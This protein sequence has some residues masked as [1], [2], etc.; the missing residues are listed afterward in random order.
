[1]NELDREPIGDLLY[2]YLGRRTGERV[3][4][5]HVRRGD[6]EKIHAVI[7]FCDLRDSTRL[8]ESM[9][10]EDFFALL[11]D[12][13]ECTAGAVL[14]HGGEILSYIGDAALAIFPIAGTDKPF[15][16]ACTPEE[17]ACA[18]ALAAARDALARVEALNSE[19]QRRGEEALRFGIALHAGDVMYGNIGVPGR[20][21]F[22]VIGAATN[23][24]SRLAG[25]CKTLDKAVLVSSR[26]PGCFP[27]QLV[28][29]GRHALQGI[30]EPQ[31]VF[32]LA[33]RQ[34]AGSCRAGC[35]AE[36]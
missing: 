18:A 34:T 14:D 31:E 23:E 20:L 12:F 19:R 13:F 4:N 15:D 29:L 21:E 25:L 26:F 2:T 7:W 6:A 5:G 27:D 22:T 28:S 35:G 11:N 33:D 16:Q 9:P 30:D 17:G 8:S 24:A 1:M 36:A 10:V 32:G 3:L